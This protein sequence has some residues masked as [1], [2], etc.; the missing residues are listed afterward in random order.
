MLQ[1]GFPIKSA[2]IDLVYAKKDILF[3]LGK[4]F[5]WLYDIYDNGKLIP[6]MKEAAAAK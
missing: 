6:A 3:A 1:A 4:I 5:L 2:Q